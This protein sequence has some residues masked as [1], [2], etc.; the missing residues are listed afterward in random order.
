MG[1]EIN[2]PMFHCRACR[3]L[4]EI[5]VA[6]PIRRR[7]DRPGYEPTTT[8]RTDIVQHVCN[9]CGAE[10]AFIGADACLK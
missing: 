3:V 2:R 1:G 9:G 5:V 4:A 8:V 10:R 6:F 7:S